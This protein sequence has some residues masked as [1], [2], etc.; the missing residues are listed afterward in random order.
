MPKVSKKGRRKSRYW[1]TCSD[2]STPYLFKEWSWEWEPSKMRAC[3]ACAAILKPAS[4]REAAE[5]NRQCP[6]KTR[7]PKDGYAAYLASAEW[8]AIRTRVLA[9]DNNRCPCGM[10]ATEVHH[11]DYS[12]AVMLG[13]DDSKLIALCHG[14]HQFISYRE[15]GSKRG[16]HETERLLVKIIKTPPYAHASEGHC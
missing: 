11:R 12:P 4:A 6:K 2:C 3:P 10:P 1:F 14:C 15:P 13:K 7:R 8:K 9:R 5:L 16:F